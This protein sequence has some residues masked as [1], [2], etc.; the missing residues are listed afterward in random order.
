MASIKDRLK[1]QKF[2]KVEVDGIEFLVKKMDYLEFQGLVGKIKRGDSNVEIE[3]IL[4]AVKDVKGLKTKDVAENVEDF[5]AEEL[6]E[7]LDFDR[8]YLQMYLGKNQE[9]LVALYGK[10]VNDFVEFTNQKEDKKKVSLDTELK[11]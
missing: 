6:E 4:S 1:A 9:A 3:L 7:T 11:E 10:V 2:I 5:T 8:E